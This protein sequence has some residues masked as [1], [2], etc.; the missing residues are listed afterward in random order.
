[1]YGIFG[2]RGKENEKGLRCTFGVGLKNFI[3]TT[4]NHVRRG[5][6]RG[7][8]E[9]EGTDGLEKW[10]VGPCDVGPIGREIRTSGLSTGL[11]PAF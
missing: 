1:M 3:L 2:K 8:G 6:R 7:R 11:S 10:G 9:D 4:R 5:W